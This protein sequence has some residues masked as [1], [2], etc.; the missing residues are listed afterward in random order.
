MLGSILFWVKIMAVI[1]VLSLCI[2]IPFL[3]V[4]Q[5]GGQIAALATGIVLA[6][7]VAWLVVKAATRW[8]QVTFLNVAQA[9]AL[10][11]RRLPDQV[12]LG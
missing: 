1:A 2:A 8:L 11:A 12:G 9:A 10:F 4:R 3:W 7:L 6:P 5:H